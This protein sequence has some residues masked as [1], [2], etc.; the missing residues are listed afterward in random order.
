MFECS[1]VRVFE[2]FGFTATILLRLTA[3]ADKKRKNKMKKLM[4]L[5]AVA[6][7]AMGAKAANTFEVS[8]IHFWPLVKVGGP[9]AD[10]I[11]NYTTMYVLTQADY[12]SWDKSLADLQSKAF[13]TATDCTWANLSGDGPETEAKWESG[14]STLGTVTVRDTTAGGTKAVIPDP[15]GDTGKTHGFDDPYELILASETDWYAIRDYNVGSAGTFESAPY[16]TNMAHGEFES[17]A[18]VPEPTSGLLLLLGV[19]GLALKRKRA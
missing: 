9:S 10:T 13:A 11:Q 3:P 1:N 14:V 12:K 18:P 2:C 5:A 4:V 7:M 19:A 15:Y 17:P 8:T 16:I 6:A